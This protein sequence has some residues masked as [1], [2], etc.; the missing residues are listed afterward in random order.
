[1]ASAFDTRACALSLKVLLVTLTGEDDPGD[2]ATT[3][4]AGSSEGLNCLA[5]W[6]LVMLPVAV[7]AIVGRRRGK[8]IAA[9]ED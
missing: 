7:L 9:A 2:H 1:V 4:S 6:A 3:I 8:R 5:V